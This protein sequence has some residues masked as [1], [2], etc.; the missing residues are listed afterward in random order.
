MFKHQEDHITVLCIC[1]DSRTSGEESGR[2]RFRRI[3]SG[4]R[5]LDLL[6]KAKF[7]FL[8]VGLEMPDMSAWDFLRLL[9]TA[10]PQ[11][12]WGLVGQ[13][14]THAQQSTARM[15]GAAALFDSIPD[16]AELIRLTAHARHQAIARTLS[17]EF[18]HSGSSPQTV[19]SGQY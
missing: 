3:G 6:R 15:F 7:D 14:I 17:G 4:R 13:R 10:W 8:L 2:V 18:E 19:Q 9:R 11:Q 1:A 16:D 12:G 5:G